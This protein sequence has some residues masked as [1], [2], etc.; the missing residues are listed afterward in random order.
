MTYAY[1]WRRCDSSGAT[2][3]SISGATGQ[4]YTLGA[5][6][7]GS[8]MRVRVTATNAAGTSSADSAPTALVSAAPPSNT[9]APSISGTAVVG[10]T[11]TA[12]S[13]SWTGTAPIS[14]ASQWLRC[15]SS[16]AN[17][18]SIVGATA[19]SYTLGSSDAGATVRVKVTASN[20]AGSTS[21]QSAPA[22][23]ASTSSAA[24]VSIYWGAGINGPDTYGYLYGGSWA[25]PP[26][27][28]NTWNKFES[29]AGKKVSIL[30]WSNSAPWVHDFNYFLSMHEKVRSRGDLSMISMNSGSVPLRDV[31]NGLYDSYLTTWAQ[32]VAA[33]GHPFFLRWNWEMNGNW[34][35]W[36]PGVNGNTASDSVAAWRH[37][38]DLAAQAGA[39]NI[40]WVWCPNVDPGGMWTPYD[41]VYPGDEYVDWTCLDGYNKGSVFSPPGWRSFSTIF[42]SSYSRLL[43][44]APS[45]PIMVGETSSEESGGS[46][47]DWINNL[48]ST[49]LPGNFQGVKALVWLNWRNYDAGLKYWWPWEIESSSSAQ[50]AFAAGI[51]SPYYAPGGTFGNL[52]LLSKIKPL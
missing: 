45:K 43:Q 29:N 3:A 22:T 28:D 11:L 50:A 34:F 21:A 6:D 18:G 16:G 49:E 36:S 9:E 47:A 26:W 1:Q 35:P 52:P 8:T 32:Q 15:D 12:S 14:Y 10:Q 44:L 31:A 48:L 24:A 20:S 33:W 2:C 25:N 39:S 27:D 51:A 19:Q 46:K 38:H 4:S 40:T 13:G 7:V 42:S 23:V 5:G 41:Q 17:C 37:F 30:S